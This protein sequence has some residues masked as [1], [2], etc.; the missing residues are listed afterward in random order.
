MDSQEQFLIADVHDEPEE[1]SPPRLLPRDWP[2]E[3]LLD[4]ISIQNIPPHLLLLIQG[5]I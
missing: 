5:S 1:Y 3:T 2:S 4:W